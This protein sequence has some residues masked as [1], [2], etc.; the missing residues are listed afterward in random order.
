MK[1]NKK[2]M[3]NKNVEKAENKKTLLTCKNRLN[4]TTKRYENVLKTNTQY[5]YIY[6]YI[7]VFIVYFH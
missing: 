7:Y 6:V 3:K 1:K 5:I 4:E 2:T